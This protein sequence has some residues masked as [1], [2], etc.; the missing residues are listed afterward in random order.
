MADGG[1]DF[2]RVLP[3]REPDGRGI[4]GV[5]REITMQRLWSA[6]MQGVFPWFCEDAG[7][8]V[9][10]WCPDPRFCIL[11][12]ELRI[13]R[14]VR[15]ELSRAGFTYTM[16]ADFPAVIRGCREMERSGQ[17]G[18][19]IG[20]KMIRA[21]T[22]FHELG[23]A[24]SVEAWLGGELAGGFYGVLIGSV[25]FG[26]SMFTRV[27][28]SSKCAF[29]LFARAF[30]EC[31]GRLIDSQVRTDNIARYGARDM[32]RD[33]FLFLERPC[34]GLP[35]ARDIREAFAEAASS[36]KSPLL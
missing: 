3:F 2:S 32:L 21:Y 25:F 35:L 23:F 36:K 4:V 27:G 5:S 34:L 22:R 18:T 13:P 20:G 28:G 15:R 24:H 9:V 33:E 17:S 29:A 26:E 7:D 11:A 19:W 16:D 1:I 8:P 6:Y 14:S 12:D 10:W 30:V 31:G